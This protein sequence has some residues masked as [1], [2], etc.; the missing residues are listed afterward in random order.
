MGT[1]EKSFTREIGKNTGKWVSNI[2]FGD[3]H[4][5][6]Y[7][8]VGGRKQQVPIYREPRKTRTEIIQE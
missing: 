8:R 3:G 6:P 5:T 2:V 4:S 1:F 7:R